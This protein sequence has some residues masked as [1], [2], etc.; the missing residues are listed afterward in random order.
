MLLVIDVGNTN[1]TLGVFALVCRTKLMK[2]TRL[3]NVTYSF[4]LLFTSHFV[5]KKW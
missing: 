4:N 1:I 5:R 2:N 3:A